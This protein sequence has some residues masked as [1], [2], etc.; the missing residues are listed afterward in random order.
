MLQKLTGGG[1]AL[2]AQAEKILSMEEDKSIRHKKAMANAKRLR[3]KNERASLSKTMMELRE[4][5]KSQKLPKTAEDS[6]LK[7]IL[8]WDTFDRATQFSCCCSG[9]EKPWALTELRKKK[10]SRLQKEL[11]R[12]KKRKK[13]ES[14][15][16]APS[17]GAN[18]TE[19]SRG[20]SRA[21]AVKAAQVAVCHV[22]VNSSCVLSFLYTNN[23]NRHTIH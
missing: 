7:F 6:I 19:I 1:G 3:A 14:G 22:H 11:E 13:R 4:H 17:T 23:S 16:N 15:N 5:V 10:A 9:N 18:D 2:G 12:R 8:I 21:R 20:G